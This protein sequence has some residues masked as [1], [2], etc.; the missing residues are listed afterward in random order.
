MFID[1][2]TFLSSIRGFPDASENQVNEN[3]AEFCYAIFVFFMAPWITWIYLKFTHLR[4]RALRKLIF[5]VH[6]VQ[7]RS[8]D[9]QKKFGRQVEF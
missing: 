7:E 8:F 9:L 4:L 2:F 1:L 6:G 5:G 3:V